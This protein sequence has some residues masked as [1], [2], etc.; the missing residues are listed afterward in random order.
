MTSQQQL[1]GTQFSKTP[2]TFILVDFFDDDHSDSSEV[3]IFVDWICMAL[4]VTDVEPF[5]LPFF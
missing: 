3:N 4:L 2:S 1:E 5:S